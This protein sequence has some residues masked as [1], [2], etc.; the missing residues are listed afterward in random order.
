MWL[1]HA[2]SLSRFNRPATV[3]SSRPSPRTGNG[4]PRSAT[5]LPP[6]GRSDMRLM[7]QVSV[8]SV[9]VMGSSPRKERRCAAVPS[10]PI[11]G[12]LLPP[13]PMRITVLTASFIPKANAKNAS[14]AVQPVPSA[15]P[16]TTSSNAGIFSLT[17]SRITRKLVLDLPVMGVGCARPG[18]HANPESRRNDP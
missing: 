7:R 8:L 12:S 13:G 18:F 11:S 2:M 10:S 4:R 6:T 3:H 14:P 5:G 9:S 15:K 16:D 17:L 1:W